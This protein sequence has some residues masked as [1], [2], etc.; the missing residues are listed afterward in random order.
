MPFATYRGSVGHHP[1]RFVMDDHHSFER[2]RPLPVCGN[3]AAMLSGTRY[4]P[5]F[6]IS[7]RRAHFGLFG[8][9]ST[10]SSGGEPAAVCC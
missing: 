5:Y 7:A 10:T 3:T 1:H 6:E 2:A 8:C 9:A 4:A